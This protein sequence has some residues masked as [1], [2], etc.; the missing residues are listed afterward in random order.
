MTSLHSQS[1]Q[2]MSSFWNCIY[3]IAKCWW[4]PET[5]RSFHHWQLAPR[6]R[7]LLWLANPK[8]Q[9]MSTHVEGETDA[10]QTELTVERGREGWENVWRGNPMQNKARCKHLLWIAANMS[11][12]RSAWNP[13]ACT[14]QNTTD[15]Y[16][17]VMQ[18]LLVVNFI[19]LQL[20]R[21]IFLTLYSRNTVF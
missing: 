14:Y 18:V 5:S 16:W 9:A 13:G 20:L 11:Q 17:K 6:W 2:K 15:N 3:C 12:S 19:K 4:V 7:L 21:R 1:L 10:H 8:N